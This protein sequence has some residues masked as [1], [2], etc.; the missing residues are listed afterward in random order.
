MNS[1]QYASFLESEAV[2]KSIVNVN[3]WDGGMVHRI[4]DLKK[5]HQAHHE[6]FGPELPEFLALDYFST[7]GDEYVR[8]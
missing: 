2:D 3:R 8:A 7:V 1:H 5:L 4:A 6:F